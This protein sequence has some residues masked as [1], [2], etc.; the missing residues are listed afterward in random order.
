M[1]K[2]FKTTED[3]AILCSFINKRME[4]FPLTKPDYA[5]AALDKDNVLLGG[6]TVEK[7]PQWYVLT[8]IAVDV[9][10]RR[11]GLGTKLITAMCEYISSKHYNTQTL[12][13]SRTT[14]Y[15]NFFLE[16]Y[17]Y[18]EINNLVRLIEGS[19]TN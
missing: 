8:G 6:I 13:I 5:Y 16:N 2:L 17:F 11:I 10:F 9:Q 15:E 18:K 4:G 14:P 3:V 7:K 12:I 1:I 19:K